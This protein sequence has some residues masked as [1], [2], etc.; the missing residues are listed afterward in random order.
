MLALVVAVGAALIASL[1]ARTAARCSGKVIVA[2][3]VPALLL[4]ACVLVFRPSSLWIVNSSVLIV[5]IATG[6]GLGLLLRNKMSLVSFLIAASIAD[7]VSATS[8]ATQEIAE[9]HRQGESDLLL[10]L[11]ITARLEGSVQQ[12]VGVGDLVLLATVSFALLRLGHR[13]PMAVTAP[14]SGLVV[15]VLIGMKTGGMFAIP[16]IVAGTLLYLALEHARAQ[17]R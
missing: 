5:A 2:C 13:G 8:G 6:A 9:L 15:A 12:I 4:Y 1:G 10:Y 11:S 17:F 7:I 14:I 16:F 3:A